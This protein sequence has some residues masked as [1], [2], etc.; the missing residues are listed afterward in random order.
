MVISY[1]PL[2]PTVLG[3]RNSWSWPPEVIITL[4]GWPLSST[5]RMPKERTRDGI[6]RSKNKVPPQ[7]AS[8]GLS[9]PFSSTIKIFFCG[10]QFQQSSLVWNSGLPPFP[11]PGKVFSSLAG[12]PAPEHYSAKNP[13]CKKGSRV[14]ENTSTIKRTTGP[15]HN[16]KVN[17]P[18][19]PSLGLPK[20]GSPSQDGPGSLESKILAA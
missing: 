7:A 20:S 10:T 1:N 11:S 6:S 2:F 15:S 17:L 18:S 13:A 5:S 3:V 12:N 9:P 19:H 14:K 4:T 8:S 16:S